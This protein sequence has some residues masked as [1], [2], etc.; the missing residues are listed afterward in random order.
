VEAIPSQ[1][2]IAPAA[3][4]A[5]PAAD[6]V[7]VGSIGQTYKVRN[8]YPVYLHDRI[9]EHTCLEPFICHAAAV[10]QDKLFQGLGVLSDFQLRLS[11]TDLIS[12]CHFYVYSP[13]TDLIL[14]CSVR[15]LLNSDSNAAS[16]SK[17]TTFD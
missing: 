17:V 1:A 6:H 16:A 14:L 9:T 12:D 5:S 11:G 8:T 10:H 3:L 4:V 13:D 2:V 15:H 7:Q